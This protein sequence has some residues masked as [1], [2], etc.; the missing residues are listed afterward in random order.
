MII[1]IYTH[2]APKTFLDRMVTLAPK[3][4]NIVNRLLNVKPLSDIDTRCRDMDRV[5]DYR[6]VLSLPNPSLEEIGPPATGLE[7]ARIANDELAELCRKYP[8][9]R[10]P[11]ISAMSMLQSAKQIAPSSSSAPRAY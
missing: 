5:P 8:A 7:L 2:I 3:L 11:C 6:Q 4:G 10:R 1:D 9:W